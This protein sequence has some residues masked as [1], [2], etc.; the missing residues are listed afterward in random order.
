MIIYGQFGFTQSHYQ[1]ITI[2][3]PVHVI[4]LTRL[5]LGFILAVKYNIT[6]KLRVK[7]QV[8]TY[9]RH[10]YYQDIVRS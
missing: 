5:T 10:K 3:C 2:L 4:A 6:V 1:I 7:Y 8:M 9:I